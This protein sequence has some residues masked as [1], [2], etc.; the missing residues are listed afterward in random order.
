MKNG[1][2]LNNIPLIVD[3]DWTL[4]NADL[5]H[6][7]LIG[8]ARKNPALIFLYPFWLL[9]GKGYL[10]DQLCKRF[11]IDVSTLP[12]NQVVIDYIKTRKKNG[13]LIILATASHKIYAFAIAK[14]LTIMHT[15][16]FEVMEN[17]DLFQA[18]KLDAKQT[19]TTPLFDDVMASHADFNLSSN[20]KADKLVQRFGNQG[21]DYMGDHRRDLPV[22]E[23]SHLSI[24][25]NVSEK[26][27]RKTQHLNTLILSKKK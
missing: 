14:Y 1:A 8:A 24:L 20:N 13:D 5:L 9:R 27:I 7:S 4:I 26:I 21:F 12:Y 22:W 2:N 25:V 16:L 15:P 23:A 6:R 19:K 10:K 11:T 18:E 3:L 17:S